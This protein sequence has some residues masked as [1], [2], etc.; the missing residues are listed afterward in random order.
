[1]IGTEKIGGLGLSRA[2]TQEADEKCAKARVA[3][4]A[5]FLK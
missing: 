1:M 3:A 5:S 4:A 2:P